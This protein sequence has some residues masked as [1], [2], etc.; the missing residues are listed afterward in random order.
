MITVDLRKQVR[1][2][3][4]RRQVS[5][6]LGDEALIDPEAQSHDRFKAIPMW[7]S[8]YVGLFNA[9]ITLN[10]I[11]SEADRILDQILLSEFI[12]GNGGE[13]VI[14]NFPQIKRRHERQCG[15]LQ[16]TT[17]LSRQINKQVFR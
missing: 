7:T 13:H 6:Q 10:G 17:D 3:A 15:H 5:V 4:V 9:H 8:R 2:E 1:E 11:V 14:Q 16:E 12:H